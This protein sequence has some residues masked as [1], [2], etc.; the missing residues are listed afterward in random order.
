M[1]AETKQLTVGEIDEEHHVEVKIHIVF[2]YT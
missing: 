2:A 1:A